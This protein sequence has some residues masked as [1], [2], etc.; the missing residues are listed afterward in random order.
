MADVHIWRIE[1]AGEVRAYANGVLLGQTTN[2]NGTFQFNIGDTFRFEAF[3]ASGWKFGSYC[4]VE[5]CVTKIT[6]SI[7]EGTI[8]S[9]T[10]NLY[11]HFLADAA[12]GSGSDAA[13]F[14]LAVGVGALL[15]FGDDR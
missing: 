9:E 4:D 3:P 7:F 15:L 6:T 8:V 14:L 1:G 2:G 10:G 11:V 5:P 13:M 12:G